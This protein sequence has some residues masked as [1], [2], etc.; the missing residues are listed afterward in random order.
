MQNFLHGDFFVSL[1]TNCDHCYI[2]C[3]QYIYRITL[4]C[5]MDILISNTSGKPIYEQIT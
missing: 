5:S 1:L 3:M 2:L 4:R